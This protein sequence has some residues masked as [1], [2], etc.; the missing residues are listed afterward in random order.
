M[1]FPTVEDG[2]RFRI[3][4]FSFFQTNTFGAQ[5]LFK[6]DASFIQLPEH[7]NTILDLYC[8]AGTIGLSLLSQRLGD[9]VIGIEIV[10]DA[11]RDAKFNAELNHLSEQS[12]FVA[13]KTEDLFST[14][15]MIREK[16]DS[17]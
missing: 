4:P 16:M 9:F 5:E 7:K 10:E 11:I 12:Y 15:T 14:D 13:G 17:V 6:K 3:S 1:K 8:G 2:I